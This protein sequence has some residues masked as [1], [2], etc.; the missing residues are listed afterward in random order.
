MAKAVEP[1]TYDAVFTAA[2]STN[3]RRFRSAGAATVVM[4]VLG[5]G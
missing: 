4:A 5:F 1:V 2:D 3:A